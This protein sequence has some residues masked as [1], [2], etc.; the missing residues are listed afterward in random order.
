VALAGFDVVS[1]Y[2]S[3]Q[4]FLDTVVEYGSFHFDEKNSIEK[5]LFIKSNSNQSFK[6]SF[7]TTKLISQINSDYTIPLNYY[8]NNN[9]FTN[10]HYFTALNGKNQGENSIGIIKFET[11][12]ISHSLIAGGYEAIVNVTISLE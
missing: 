6:I 3:G 12:T 10:N 5:S 1:S 9:P 8:F 4:R 7:D 2:T 11:E